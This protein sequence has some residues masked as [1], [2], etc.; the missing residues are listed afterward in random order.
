MYRLKDFSIN[1]GCQILLM[2]VFSIKKSII[3]FIK[4]ISRQFQTK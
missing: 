1:K 3:I 4:N 2:L